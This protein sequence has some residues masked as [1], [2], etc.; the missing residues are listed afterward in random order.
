V[1]TPRGGIRLGTFVGAPIIL[2]PSWFLI[3]AFVVFTFAPTV[4]DYLP[5]L[6]PGANYLVAAT[7]AVLLLLSVLVH[8]LA[9]AVLAKSYGL[10]VTEIV[11]DLWGGHTQFA[12]EATQPLPS[13]VVSVGGPAANLLLALVGLVVRESPDGVV[14]LLGNAL[15]LA[16][17]LLAIFNLL[18][19][20]PLDGGRVVESLFWGISGERSTGT[21][22]AGWLG[23]AVAVAVLFVGFV[24][25]LV[26][27]GDPDLTVVIWSALISGLLWT[28]ASQALRWASM[29][30]RATRLD[31][32]SLARPAVPVHA[33]WSAREVQEL[34]AEQRVAD[35]V[36]LDESGIPVGLVAT[37]AVDHM[38]ATG[39][40][41]VQVQSLMHALPAYAVL[42]A[43]TTGE[44]LLQLLSRT[45]AAA[46]YA[47]VD[48]HGRVGLVAGRDLVA[49]MS[50]GGRS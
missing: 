13:A 40:P 19:G 46:T 45:P 43:S 5:D 34:A 41:D 10:P 27:S 4:K 32:R 9:H 25:P 8:E 23:R 31:A 28:G 17:L 21:L 49:A 7:Y 37:E 16:N 50:G 39:R 6:S 22:V 18:P 33:T 26:R 3:A 36:V 12:G 42:P 20:L 1:D 24:L 38:V 2:S 48:E 44:A 11:A 47:L 29:R 35:I 15:F 14:A 30:R